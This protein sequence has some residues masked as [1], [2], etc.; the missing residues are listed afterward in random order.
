MYILWWWYML[1]VRMHCIVC[2]GDMCV[3]HTVKYPFIRT[4]Y[5]LIANKPTKNPN[6]SLKM[7]KIQ[8]ARLKIEWCI[9]Y[10]RMCSILFLLSVWSTLYSWHLK[11][12]YASYVLHSSY[13]M[14]LGIPIFSLFAWCV[15]IGSIQMCIYRSKPEDKT[16]NLHYYIY[17]Q[18]RI[19]CKVVK[20]Q[21]FKH[22]A[23]TQ[24]L[25]SKIH[26]EHKQILVIWRTSQ[27]IA[28]WSFIYI[29]LANGCFVIYILTI[30]LLSRYYYASIIICIVD[31]NRNNIFWIL[32][33]KI[34]YL[35]A[36]DFFPLCIDVKI[37][38]EI[39]IYFIKLVLISFFFYIAKLK[40]W[41]LLKKK[42]KRFLDILLFILNYFLFFNLRLFLYLLYVNF[43]FYIHGV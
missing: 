31:V 17:L 21:T 30:L 11:K 19:K 16:E 33:Y 7:F 18:T 29:R 26:M 24:K 10:T 25:N 9:V 41:K 12:K 34:H 15:P 27:I 5:L 39:A 23:V 14:H 38:S 43:N 35:K 13:N 20:L 2:E 1:V 4:I 42:P 36:S 40:A 37:W 3:R 28:P 22:C 32:V 8:M 6:G